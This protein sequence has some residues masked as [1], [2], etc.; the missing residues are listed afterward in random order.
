[1]VRF[2]LLA[3]ILGFLAGC[4][5]ALVSDPSAVPTKYPSVGVRQEN[6]EAKPRK[7][8]LQAGEAVPLLVLEDQKGY[9][10][11]TRE[12]TTGGDALLIFHGGARSPEAR[13]VYDWVRENL[14]MADS[15]DCEILLVGPDLPE[16]NEKVAAAEELKIGI[17]CD[18]SGWGARAF[19][20]LGRADST[21]VEGIW[22]V[23][24]GREGRVLEVRRGLYDVSDLVTVLA[25]RPDARPY[26]A[27]DLPN[28]K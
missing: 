19:G 20:L 21:Q 12:L 9:L 8:P 2:A 11:S 3:V 10:V 23:V 1:M 15:R 16:T 13:P 25:V 22:S 4:G 24:I 6:L 26:R 14:T 28:L 27:M 5:G 18:P 17:L 7:A